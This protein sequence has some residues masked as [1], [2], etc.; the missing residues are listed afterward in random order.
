MLNSFSIINR[1]KCHHVGAV[2][3]KATG[4]IND[5]SLITRC[6]RPLPVTGFPSG[7]FD[8]ARRSNAISP[9]VLGSGEKWGFG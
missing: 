6:T 5:V 2:S 8:H 4:T 7:V 9:A 3:Y 1:D